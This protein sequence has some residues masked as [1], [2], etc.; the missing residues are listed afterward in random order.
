MG[1]AGDPAAGIAKQRGRIAAAVQ[2]HDHLSAADRWRRWPASRAATGPARSACR[3]KSTSAKR[4]AAAVPGRLRQHELRIAP[5]RGILQAL[6][7]RRRRTQDDRHIGALCPPAPPDRGPNSGTPRAACRRRRAPR[8][9]RSRESLGSGGEHGG[10]GADDDAGPPAMR[11]SPRVAPLGS[12]E[13]R[14][15]DDDPGAEAPA[16]AVHELRRECD[17]G[18]QHQGLPAAGERRG[19]GPQVHLGLAA[20]G[21]AVQEMRR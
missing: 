19:N 13:P 14:M 6:Q 8:R 15:H 16:E 9:P 21:H 1:A 7:R 20:A 10:A 11:G 5:L 17:F 18:H 4:G 12:G 3:R 2:E